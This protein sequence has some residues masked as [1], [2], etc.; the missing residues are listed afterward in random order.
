MEPTNP[1][2]TSAP[3]TNPVPLTNEEVK[4][5]NCNLIAPGIKNRSV[6]AQILVWVSFIIFWP[7]T[8]LYYTINP[9]YKC[10]NC[11][12]TFVGTKDKNGQWEG[13]KSGAIILFILLGILIGIAVL[14]ILS[15]IVLASLSSARAKGL[16][17]RDKA[18]SAIATT[19]QLYIEATVEDIKKTTKFPVVVDDNLTWVDVAAKP[20][21]IQFNYILKDIGMDKISNEALKEG[22]LPDIC[23]SELKGVLDIGVT[24]RDEFA[25][26]NSSTTFAFEV[27]KSDCE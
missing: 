16:E 18:N 8:L 26:K 13:Q 10:S 4:C 9:K 27:N 1:T 15:S 5:G 7:I 23:K 14:G 25:V 20:K 22:F 19:T 21:A 2:E 11:S 17:A 24:I 12:S 3:I 6:W